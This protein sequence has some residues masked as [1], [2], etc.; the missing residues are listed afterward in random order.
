MP[1]VTKETIDCF[2]G[3]LVEEMAMDMAVGNSQ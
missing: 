3:D 2:I 1:G